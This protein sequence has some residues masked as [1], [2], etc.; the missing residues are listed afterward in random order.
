MKIKNH[1]WADGMECGNAPMLTFNVNVEAKRRDVVSVFVGT[2]SGNDVLRHVA[3][4]VGMSFAGHVR[5]MRESN[6]RHLFI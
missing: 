2:A 1:W 3:I 5:P 6:G 4:I